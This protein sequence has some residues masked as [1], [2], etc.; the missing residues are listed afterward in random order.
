MDLCQDFVMINRSGMKCEGC[1]DWFHSNCC[2]FDD[3]HNELS[4]LPLSW[5]CPSCDYPNFSNSFLNKSIESLASIN[6]FAPLRN[7]P[8]M[9]K[10]IPELSCRN[11][12]VKFRKRSKTHRADKC[13]L[14]CLLVN[15]QSVKNKV[16]EF[17]TIVAQ[18]EL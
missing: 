6:T 16:A 15:C 4:C 8:I 14:T 3:M 18:H 7:L 12:K 13:K 5:L 9:A 2:G 10:N 17:E 1:N 11:S